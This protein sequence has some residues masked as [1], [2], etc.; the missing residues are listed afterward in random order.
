MRREKTEKKTAMKKMMKSKEKT[1]RT[2]MGMKVGGEEER[3]ES[4]RSRRARA[5][6]T[7]ASWQ[8]ARS[9]LR[10]DDGRP[11]CRC[12]RGGQ[13]ELDNCSGENSLDYS[14]ELST[15][16]WPCASPSDAWLR[17]IMQLRSTLHEIHSAEND[18]DRLERS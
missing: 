5:R 12:W 1:A 9:R 2:M 13:E 18:R 15:G 7:G 3:T 17:M 6:Q 11:P 16:C 14:T 4:E 8:I 10:V